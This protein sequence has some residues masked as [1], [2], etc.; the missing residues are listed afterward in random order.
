MTAGARGGSIMVMGQLAKI[1]IQ[2]AGVVVIS[3]LL[4]PRDFGVVAMVA[5]FLALGDLIRDFG[6][7]TAALQARTLSQQQ[8][9]NAFWVN[10]A[11]GAIAAVLIVCFS[12]LLSSLYDE[13][14]LLQIGPAMALSVLLNGV[15]SQVQ[16]QLARAG[17][18]WEL[19]K[20][21]LLAQF[22]GLVA[23][24]AAGLAGWGPWAL[25]AQLLATTG[26]LVVVR[27]ATSGWRPSRPRRNAGTAGILTSGSQLGTAQILTF[28]ANNVDSVMIGWRW[29]AS[30]LGIYNRAF[31]LFVLPRTAILEPLTQ[32]VVPMLNQAREQGRR[33]LDLLLSVQFS[34]GVVVVGVYSVLAATA[35][36]A[37]AVVLGDQWQGSAEILT[38]LAIAGMF[39]AFGTVSYWTFIVEGL[40]RDLLYLHLITKPLTILCVAVA[41]QHGPLA[42]A[43]GYALATALSWP[44][45]LLWLSKRAGQ[46]SLAFLRIGTH[47]LVAA[48]ASFVSTR[49]VLQRFSGLSTWGEL[50]VGMAMGACVFLSVVALTPRA[51]HQLSAMLQTAKSLAMPTDRQTRVAG[52]G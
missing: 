5:V 24:I 45:N 37:I 49:F 44:V 41:V 9:S 10:S 47:L 17:R 3:R 46:D 16:V 6:I 19:V 13:P 33:P 20:T 35:E 7:P 21:D 23:A 48:A 30:P 14:I 1:L 2:L 22:V 12:P 4:N 29:G 31:Q 38:A 26:S 18:F 15:Q 40:S 43:Y 39:V 34:L 36:P 52:D 8:A 11:L 28:A 51:R 27:F 25:V 32:V 42:V 50:V